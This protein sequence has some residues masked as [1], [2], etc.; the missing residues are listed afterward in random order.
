MHIVENLSR[1]NDLVFTSQR[2]IIVDSGTHHSLHSKC[3]HQI[4]HTKLSLKIYYCPPHSREVWHYKDSRD[5]L[6]R[7]EINQLNWERTLKILK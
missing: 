3:C 6:T 4:I 2:E 1:C 7:I 5:N